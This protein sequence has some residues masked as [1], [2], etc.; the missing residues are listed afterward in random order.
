[1]T[2]AIE[3]KL[4][5]SEN[6]KRPTPSAI[7]PT[8]SEAQIS[9]NHS[10]SFLYGAA[11]SSLRNSF[12]IKYIR[13]ISVQTDPTASA[14]KTCGIRLKKKLSEFQSQVDRAPMIKRTTRSGRW[15]NPTFAFTPSPSE[16]AV[17]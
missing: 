16:R 3:T 13:W 6:I 7:L 2:T 12:Q 10:I 9:D 8:V 5:A 4:N 17:V 15:R 14:H 1:M 11:V